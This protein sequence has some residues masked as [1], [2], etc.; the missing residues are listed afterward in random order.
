LLCI[1]ALCHTYHIPSPS[2]SPW[3]GQIQVQILKVLS[4]W[5]SP[6]PCYFLPLR[7]TYLP[8]HPILQHP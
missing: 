5:L 1:P 8:Q 6:L 3:L 4:M 7:P 2:N